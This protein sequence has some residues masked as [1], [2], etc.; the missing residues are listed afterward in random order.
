MFFS[1]FCSSSSLN[2]KLS[3]SIKNGISETNGKTSPSPLDSA[4]VF[5]KL[6]RCHS[7]QNNYEEVSNTFFLSI[8]VKVVGLL[9]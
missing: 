4:Q 5:T 7:T 2:G 1:F 9:K 8:N 3:P 6:Q